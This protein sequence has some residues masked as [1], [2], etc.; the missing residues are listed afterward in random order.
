MKGTNRNA[1][2][3]VCSTDFLLSLQSRVTKPGIALFRGKHVMLQIQLVFS[4][5]ALFVRIELLCS[6]IRRLPPNRADGVAVFEGIVQE[7]KDKK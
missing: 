7:P 5:I 6:S 4:A 3:H 1:T 2:Q